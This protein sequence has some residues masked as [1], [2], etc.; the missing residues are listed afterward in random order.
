MPTP[1]ETDVVCVEHIVRFAPTAAVTDIHTTKGR[2]GVGYF[3]AGNKLAA[4]VQPISG[5]CRRAPSWAWA[6]G[7]RKWFLQQEV[8]VIK[9]GRGDGC[10]TRRVNVNHW[11]GEERSGGRNNVRFWHDGG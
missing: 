4:G 9:I 5:E 6:P 11:K 8:A 7:W 10:S 2:G 1:A 3:G